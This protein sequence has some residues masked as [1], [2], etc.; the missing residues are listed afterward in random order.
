MTARVHSLC[1]IFVAFKQK[2][3]LAT[4]TSCFAKAY[5]CSFIS[6]RSISSPDSQHFK[7]LTFNYRLACKLPFCLSL[8]KDPDFDDQKKVSV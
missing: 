8:P 1:N 3:N 2:M 4:E 7:R 5:K 6:S